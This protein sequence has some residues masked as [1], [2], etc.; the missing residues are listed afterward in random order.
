MRQKSASGRRKMTVKQPVVVLEERPEQSV[1]PYDENLLE[2]ARTQWQFGDWESLAQID[3]NTLQHH[4]DRAKLALLAAAGQLQTDN[5]TQSRQLI[6]LAQD[7]GIGK[8]LITQ[9]LLA[10]V[11]NSLGRAAAAVGNQARA[12][13]HFEGAIVVGMPGS[14]TRLLVQARMGEQIQQLNLHR[15]Q[16]H[17]TDAIQVCFETDVQPSL[18]VSYLMHVA[19]QLDNSSII[20][21]GMNTVNAEWIKVQED[22]I[23]Y[24]TENNSPLYLI[25]SEDGNFNKQ[26]SNRQIAIVTDTPYLLS[27]EIAHVG[28]GAPIIWI[29]QYAYGKKIDAHSIKTEMGQFRC[30][31]K[32]RYNT[33]TISIGLR[34][35]GSGILHLKNTKFSLKEMSAEDWF[36]QFEEKIEKIR[37]IQKR[38]VENSMKQI[39]ASIRLQ[40]YLGPDTLLPEMHNWPISPDFGVLLINLIE[41]NSYDVVIEFGSGTSTVILAK[42]LERTTKRAGKTPVPFLSFDHLQEYAAKTQKL[43]KQAGL[44]DVVHVVL[45][46]L[47]PWQDDSTNTIAYYACKES[48]QT[49]KQQLP[50]V[51]TRILVIVDGPPAATGRHARYPALPL[52]LEVFSGNY[53]VDFLLDDYLRTEEQEIVTRWLEMLAERRLPHTRVEFN[54]LEK[55]ACL[56]EVRPALTQEAQ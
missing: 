55:K 34:F 28:D 48:L 27:G 41:Q 30:S 21:L 36:Q 22:I 12:F 49:L 8:K 29:F 45:A 6:R 5:I 3:R 35:S 20:K 17:A 7:W 53:A 4:P 52:I 51:F 46:A 54:T 9:L 50:E 43:L 10:S 32:T 31:F 15:L 23:T 25:S 42:A 40:H 18:P 33:E 14:D 1:V 24:Q 38:E 47:E 44:A 13:K 39:E 37:Q 2:R 16:A 11:H 19:L 56:I 26:P